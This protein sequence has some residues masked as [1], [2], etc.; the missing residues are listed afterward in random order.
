VRARKNAEVGTTGGFRRLCILSSFA[1]LHDSGAFGSIRMALCLLINLLT[2]HGADKS[3]AEL[4]ALWRLEY[5][6]YK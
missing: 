5:R 6:S 2:S 3:L 4:Q 1:R